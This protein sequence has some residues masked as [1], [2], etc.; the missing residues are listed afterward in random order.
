MMENK[1]KPTEADGSPVNDAVPKS[2][3]DDKCPRCGCEE[4]E[5]A[6]EGYDDDE[7]IGSAYKCRGCNHIWVE[8][9]EY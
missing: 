1:E 2:P 8:G 4:F 3:G 6:G 9:E 5:Y 7:Y